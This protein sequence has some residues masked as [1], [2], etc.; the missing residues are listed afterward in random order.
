[1]SAESGLTIEALHLKKQVNKRTNL[2]QDISLTI[3][4]NEF[5]AVVGMSGAGKT[6]LVD[7]ISGFRPAT[8]G[9]VLINGTDFYRYYDS[10]RDDIGYVPQRDIVHMELTPEKAL[11]YAAQLRMPPDTSKAERGKVVTEVLE[12]LDLAERRKL[13]IFRMSG[14]QQKRLSI[15][16]ELLTKPRLFFLDEPTSGLDPGTEFEM[17][18]LM[19][20]LADQGRTVVLITHATKNVMMCDKG[21]ILARG[22]H[23]AYYGP[24]EIALTYFDQYRTERER[25]EKE[26]EF[27]DIYLILSDEQRGAPVEWDQRFRASLDQGTQLKLSRELPARDR[28]AKQHPVAR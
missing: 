18:K 13:P 16:V 21:V 20:R 12:V 26:I 27:D 4:S 25:R 2:L 7:A 10:F 3:N 28:P 24:P 6:T 8:D 9:Q 23:L 15:G 19:R 22:G 1:M 5:V 17:M 11:D 14:G